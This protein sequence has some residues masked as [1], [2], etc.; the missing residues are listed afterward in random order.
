MTKELQQHEVESMVM[1]WEQAQEDFGL[2]ITFETRLKAYQRDNE[3]LA[4]D[5]MDKHLDAI[6]VL[7]GVLDIF[8]GPLMADYQDAQYAYGSFLQVIGNTTRQ[9]QRLLRILAPIP[10]EI[11]TQCLDTVANDRP[12]DELINGIDHFDDVMLGALFA[13]R[14]AQIVKTSF[15]DWDSG[16]VIVGSEEE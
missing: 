15:E 7:L 10:Q 3:A 9:F 4:K 6:N 5:Y 8:D 11:I 2:R 1:N 14:Q 13:E 12:M 16:N